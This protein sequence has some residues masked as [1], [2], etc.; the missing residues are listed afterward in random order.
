MWSSESGPLETFVGEK[1]VEKGQG[2]RLENLH[3]FLVCEAEYRPITGLLP[4][5]NDSKAFIYVRSIMFDLDSKETG[6]LETFVCVKG[7]KKNKF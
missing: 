1:G 7:V 4:F 3:P 2:E 6:P 5:R